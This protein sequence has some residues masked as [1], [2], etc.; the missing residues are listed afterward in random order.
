MKFQE[1]KAED[2]ELGRVCRASSSP[3]L[4]ELHSTVGETERKKNKSVKKS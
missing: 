3:F 4:I 1:K 2:G